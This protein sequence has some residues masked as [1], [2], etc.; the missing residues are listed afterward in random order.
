MEKIVCLV[1]VFLTVYFACG[2]TSISVG[3]KYKIQ[4]SVLESERE[5]WVGL[6][7]TYDSRKAYPT[8]YVLDAESQFDIVLSVVKELAANDKIPEH[9]VVGLPHINEKHRFKDLTFTTNTYGTGGS[10]DASMAAH[11]TKENTSGGEA[12]YRHI[13]NEVIPFVES[14]YKTNGFDVL[15]GHSL[16]GYF[17]AYV[18]TME[19]PFEAYQLY[20]PSIWY[21]KAN[22]INHFAETYTKGLKAQVFITTASG[23]IVK[24]TYN[25]NTHKQFCTTLLE[26]GIQAEQRI[27]PTEYHGSVRLPSIIDGLTRLYKGYTFGYISPTDQVTVQDANQHYKTFSDRV[28]YTF[29]CPLEVYRWVAYANKHQKKWTEAIKAYQL[30]LD[31]YEKDVN[32]CTELADCYYNIKNY[33]QS[34]VYYKKALH[35]NPNDKSLEAKIN[36]TKQ[37]L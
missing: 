26:K 6:P 35:L 4:S 27:Y 28:N 1:S 30:S 31:I 18:I 3:E 25:S 20:E 5:V 23:G 33:K 29:T 8:L 36:K 37:N 13:K 11:F 24:P 12:F 22:I 15:M 19:S 7:R 21:N 32:V 34:L 10:P 14:N 9:L 2:Q 17:G 16:S